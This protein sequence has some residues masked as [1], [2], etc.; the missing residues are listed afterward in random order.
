LLRHRKLDRTEKA[1]G[2]LSP[3]ADVAIATI[4]ASPVQPSNEALQQTR[5]ALT[6][7]AAAL[8]AERRCWADV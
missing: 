6:S 1:A 8:A 4:T 3:L 2:L 5:S 7:I